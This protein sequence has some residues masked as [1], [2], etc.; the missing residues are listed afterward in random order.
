MVTIRN[1]CSLPIRDCEKAGKLVSFN[2]LPDGKEHVALILGEFSHEK[3]PLVRIHS[4]CLTGDVFHSLKCDCGNQ[5]DEAVEKI[6]KHGGVIFY[7]RQEGRGIGL[8]NKID[9]YRLQENGF[10]TFEANLHLG[11]D[12]DSRRYDVVADMLKALDIREILLLTNNNDKREALLRNGIFVKEI[13]NTKAFVNAHNKNY[14]QSKV[15]ITGH[16]ITI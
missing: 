12:K 4:E 16:N 14:L 7:L 1:V 2:N 3:I 6:N 15:A 11:F 13:L 5:L 8:Y 9:A 10:D